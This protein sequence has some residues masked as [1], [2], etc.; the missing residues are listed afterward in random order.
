MSREEARRGRER[1]AVDAE[2][3]ERECERS[4]EAEAHAP[5][6]DGRA[7]VSAR[8]CRGAGCGGR[9]HYRSL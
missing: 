4:K 9:G 5:Q 7:Q 2:E 8:R 3:A 1:E 6:L